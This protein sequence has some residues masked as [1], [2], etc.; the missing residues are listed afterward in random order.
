VKRA[1]LAGMAGLA[2]AGCQT[3]PQDLGEAMAACEKKGGMLAIIYT[4]KVSLSGV[5]PEVASPGDCLMPKQF[6]K[7][8]ENAA[9]AAPESKPAGPANGS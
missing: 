1:A 3:K 6:E 2:L 5:E 8:A 9:A 4:Q 7:P